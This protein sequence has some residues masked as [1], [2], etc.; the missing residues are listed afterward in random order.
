MSK[1]A[2]DVMEYQKKVPYL[3]LAKWR[4]KERVLSIQ[5]KIKK[6]Q[7]IYNDNRLFI[8]HTC[9]TYNDGSPVNLSWCDFTFSSKLYPD[10]AYICF[11]QTCQ[12]YMSDCVY[13][14]LWHQV[15]CETKNEPENQEFQERLKTD[16]LAFLEDKTKYAKFDNRTT[17]EE[18]FKRYNEWF[19]SNPNYMIY[20]RVLLHH[21]NNCDSTKIVEN[22]VPL[23]QVF[24]PI[25]NP[26]LK[27]DKSHYGIV[28]S[29]II[30][31]PILTLETINEFIINF[32]ESGERAFLNTTP[33]PQDHLL[34]DKD[35][36]QKYNTYLGNPICFDD[37]RDES[38]FDC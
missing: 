7:K 32:K 17:T 1:N 28:L 34:Y 8:T 30:D 14:Y 13:Y 6:Q 23:Y 5:N 29:A 3:K 25:N 18:V 20:E 11:L 35:W 22:D 15:D 4:R 36:M 26:K 33:V 37:K 12:Y 2:K 19:E 38:V 27:Y 24:D 21:Y 9:L 31:K 10:I 16:K